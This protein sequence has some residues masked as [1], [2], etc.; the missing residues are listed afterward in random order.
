[1]SKDVT[2]ELYFNKKTKEILLLNFSYGKRGTLS[3][4]WGQGNLLRCEEDEFRVKGW[5]IISEVIKNQPVFNPDDK[6]EIG[7]MNS[8][9]QRK[10]Y[11][12]H[13]KVGL[14][15][16]ARGEVQLWPYK[17]DNESE[18]MIGKEKI[19]LTPPVSNQIFW[20]KLMEAFEKAD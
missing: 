1:M 6:S 2:I 8:A 18:G 16:Y 12:T 20:E 17:K 10:F 9:E 7:R 4:W 13:K 5:D 14:Y 11:N 15:F 3:G 19:P